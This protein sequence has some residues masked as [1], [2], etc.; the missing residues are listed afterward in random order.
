MKHHPRCPSDAQTAPA[1]ATAAQPKPTRKHRAESDPGKPAAQPTL[2]RRVK[3]PAP[4]T[5][6]KKSRTRQDERIMQQLEETHARR[7]AAEAA[8]AHQG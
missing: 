8:V 6:I 5:A 7:M 1:A 2:T 3:A 4:A